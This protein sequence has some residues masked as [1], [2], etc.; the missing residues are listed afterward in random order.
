MPS[1][2]VNRDRQRILGH[3]EFLEKQR[4]R[5]KAANNAKSHADHALER[6]NKE[7]GTTISADDVEFYV[8]VPNLKQH[9]RMKP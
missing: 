3:R 5:A 1:R 4:Q 2:Q 6:R 9:V 8:T 7:R